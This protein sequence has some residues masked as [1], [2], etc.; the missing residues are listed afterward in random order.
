MFYRLSN[1]FLVF[2]EV[3]SP[4]FPLI[5]FLHIEDTYRVA[6]KEQSS[7]LSLQDLTGQFFKKQIFI[8]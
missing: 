4:S 3:F 2:L 5:E 1:L 8:N 7:V 6:I